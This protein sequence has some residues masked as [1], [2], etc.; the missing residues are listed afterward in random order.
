MIFTLIILTHTNRAG[1]ELHDP[2]GVRVCGGGEL[3]RP[4]GHHVPHQGHAGQIR[5][6][7]SHSRRRLYPPIQLVWLQRV[8]LDARHRLRAAPPPGPGHR[9]LRGPVQAGNTD[10]ELN[11]C[12]M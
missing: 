2:G 7:R 12:L 11:I 10:G 8:L 1:H 3:P 9:L 4:Q 6:V 5:S